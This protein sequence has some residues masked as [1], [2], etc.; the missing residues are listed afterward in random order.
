[1]PI[2][3][4]VNEHLAVTADQVV[5]SHRLDTKISEVFSNQIDCVIL[6]YSWN[7]C[8][9]QGPANTQLAEGQVLGKGQDLWDSQCREEQEQL[10]LQRD[11]KRFPNH[12]GPFLWS[13]HRLPRGKSGNVTGVMGISN[14]EILNN[15]VRLQ[16]RTLVLLATPGIGKKSSKTKEWLSLVM[17]LH[18]PELCH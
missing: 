16:K 7:I 11:L 8:G 15:P 9:S 13:L 14:P 12:V 1:M 18:V 6:E 4:G 10:E 3:G 5:I 17:F 2:P